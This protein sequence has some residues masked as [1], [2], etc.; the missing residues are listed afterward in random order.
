MEIEF[1]LAVGGLVSALVWCVLKMAPAQEFLSPLH[2]DE[3]EPTRETR[4]A[5]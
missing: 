2:I 3:H 1:M 5:A 4:K